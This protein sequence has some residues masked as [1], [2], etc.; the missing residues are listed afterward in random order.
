MAEPVNVAVHGV[1]IRRGG[2][3]V[4]A[5]VEL[6]LGP[7]VFELVG[8]NGSGKSTLLRALAGVGAIH[9]GRIEIAG[10]DLD[11]DP[12]EARRRLG[13]MPE[14]AELFPTLTPRELLATFAAVRGADD[15]G[16]AA[17]ASL[18]RPGALDLRICTLSAGQRRKLALVAAI[19]SAPT[20]WLLDEPT[21][22]LDT[23]ANDFLRTA[24]AGHCVRAGT[25]LVATHRPGELGVPVN[26][27]LEVAAGRVTGPA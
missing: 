17:Y 12:I 10:F 8:A 21:D 3:D 22:T 15:D 2:R 14:T 25:V 27:V 5:D 23:A 6:A 26:A 24:I 9:R 13:Y 16:T 20:V 18:T 11:R 1:A 7:G 19:Q 4:L